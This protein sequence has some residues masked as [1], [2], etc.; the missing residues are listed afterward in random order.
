VGDLPDLRSPKPLQ[1][2][3]VVSRP[4]LPRSKSIR[5]GGGVFKPAFTPSSPRSKRSAASRCLAGPAGPGHRAGRTGCAAGRL[6]PGQRGVLGQ[7][8]VTTCS[9]ARPLTP[10]NAEVPGN[11]RTPEQGSCFVI[12][13]G[14]GEVRS[15]FAMTGASIR[16]A[17]TPP[18][19]APAPCW[20]AIT[21][22]TDGQ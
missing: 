19:C 10:A 18:S 12:A 6:C 8:W 21:I 3:C 5:A 17:A 20:T 2:S 9:A 4:C 11:V 7:P 1:R 14:P 15:C 16:R 22:A 13:F